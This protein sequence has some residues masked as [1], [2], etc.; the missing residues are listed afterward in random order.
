[1]NG[2]EILGVASDAT[3]EQIK[4]AYRTLASK[5]HPDIGGP[6][7]APLFRTV[8]AAYET[9][10]DPS[11]RAAYDRELGGVRTAPAPPEPQPKETPAEKT[12]PTPPNTESRPPR[13]EAPRTSR[14][15]TRPTSQRAPKRR[16]RNIHPVLAA[17]IAV[18]IFA[19]SAFWLRV[20]TFW[21]EEPFQETGIYITGSQGFTAGAYVTAWIFSTVLVVGI[22][23]WTA[24]LAPFGAVILSG[25]MVF[26]TK[27][28]YPDTVL[29]S[30]ALGLILTWLIGWTIRRQRL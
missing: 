14:G 24:W 4:K 23:H 11:R 1:M 3:P 2:Y 10:S 12:R 29:L 15:A 27:T 22:R 20:V 6:A 9:L 19:V 13:P 21:M 26:A 8:Q 30:F 16:S 17:I 18:L 25:Y 5:T 7:M 28:G